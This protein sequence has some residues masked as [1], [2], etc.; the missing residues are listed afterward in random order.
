MSEYTLAFAEETAIDV[1][2]TYDIDGIDNDLRPT[3]AHRTDAAFDLRASF[4]RMMAPGEIHAIGCGIRL[5]LPDSFAGLVLARSGLAS[6]GITVANSP[7]LIDAGYRGEVRALLH[8]ETDGDFLVHK[9]D[10]IAQLLIISLPLV[11][12]GVVTQTAFEA[13]SSDRGEGGFGST[14]L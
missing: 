6:R 10:R 2:F 3:K 8:N 14:G 5:A 9:G 12:L 13:L 1:P 7:G 4:N 11:Q